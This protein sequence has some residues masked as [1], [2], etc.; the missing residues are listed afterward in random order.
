MWILE[1]SAW[2]VIGMVDSRV[3]SVWQVIRMEG[4]LGLSQPASPPLWKLKCCAGKHFVIM[5]VV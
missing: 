5:G 2:Q 4:D 3:K 1:K